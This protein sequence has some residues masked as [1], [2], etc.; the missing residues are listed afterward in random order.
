LQCSAPADVVNPAIKLFITPRHIANDPAQAG[1]AY[2]VQ[3]PTQ[4]RSRPCLQP[5]C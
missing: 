3:M 4:A 2:D 5:E 1:R